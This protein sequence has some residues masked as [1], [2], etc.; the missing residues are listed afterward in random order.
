MDAMVIDPGRQPL[1]P[2]PWR[3]FLSHTSD[4]RAHPEERS[5]VDAAE[6]AVVRAGHAVADM[7]YFAARDMRPADYCTA[8]VSEAH[9]YVGIIGAS[10]GST[11]R[12][13]SELSY[14]ELE[15][16]AASVHGL[17]RLVFL[18]REDAASL[19]RARQPDEHAARQDGFRRR[20]RESGITIAWV[21]S[22]LE[23]ELA[24]LQALNDLGALSKAVRSSP[25]P[26]TSI[27]VGDL[28]RARRELT[29]V[30]R[31]T[32][33]SGVLEPSLADVT[34]V[35]VKLLQRTAAVVHPWGSLGQLEWP[36]GDVPAGMSIHEVVE[37]V[38]GHLLILGDS[39]S[40]KTCLLLRLADVLLRRASGD[41]SA[42]VP[43]VCHLSG[44]PSGRPSL[45][46]WLVEELTIRYGLPRRIARHYVDHD[47]L[48]VLLDGLDELAASRREACAAAIN[49]YRAEHGWVRLVVCSR[50]RDYEAMQCRLRLDGAVVIQPLTAAQVDAWLETAGPKVDGLRTAIARSGRPI[51]RALLT[52]PLLLHVAA[53]AY[54]DRPTSSFDAGMDLR[55]ILDSYVATALVRPRSVLAEAGER[56]AYPPAS[57]VRWLGWLAA[58]LQRR[59]LALFTVDWMQP[60]WL[61]TPGQ[62]WLVVHGLNILFGVAGG[63]ALGVVAGLVIG[64]L[65]GMMLGLA[66]GAISG[67]LVGVVVDLVGGQQIPIVE[68][69]PLSWTAARGGSIVGATVC[70][71]CAMV[72]GLA[73]ALVIGLAAA[74]AGALLVALGAGW[75]I[76]LGAR[77][78][79]QHEVQTNPRLEAPGDGIKA[80][81]RTG[82]IVGLAVGLAGG[83][84]VGLLIWLVDGAPR[85]LVAGI[86]SGLGSAMAGGLV[87]GGMNYPRHHLLRALLRRNGSLPANLTDFLDYAESHG[88]LRRAG[89]SYLFFHRLLQEHLSSSDG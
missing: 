4:L 67:L 18:V 52:T 11:V 30:V 87:A 21:A 49:S 23:L 3:V 51:L 82:A 83:V 63:L 88:L 5:F 12:D 58:Q 9:V 78:I 86:A 46:S 73:P 85:G 1:R 42:P 25:D 56:T 7:G 89:G 29:E 55:Q 74:L 57:T 27:P 17:P 19:P 66:V 50:S 70:L 81:L 72:V 61:P 24:L 65:A 39:G 28:A 76:K 62:R 77:T 48:S 47:L 71:V 84:G 53:H 15:F 33:I 40:G 26:A 37:R 13:R 38:G 41:P 10:Y 59:E 6:A 32:W 20:L 79:V 34:P 2:P 64:M 80:A 16:E 60:D 36:G 54:C 31:R 45:E 43:I 44:W 8:M 35:E 69:E 14:T 75:G 22:P 68:R